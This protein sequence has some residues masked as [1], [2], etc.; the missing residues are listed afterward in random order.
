MFK[1][2]NECQKEYNSEIRVTCI[3]LCILRDTEFYTLISV[4]SKYLHSKEDIL[5]SPLFMLLKYIPSNV[6]LSADASQLI[7]FI[8][9]LNSM[10]INSVN[11]F[12]LSEYFG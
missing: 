12:G 8:N 5:Q 4:V 6:Y 2:I 7:Y 1:Y 10:K 11:I 3:V 9:R